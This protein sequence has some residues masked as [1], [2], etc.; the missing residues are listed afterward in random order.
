MGRIEV[1]SD[2]EIRPDRADRHG[3]PYRPHLPRVM[4][5]A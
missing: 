1:F 2:R 3:N 4:G 5:Y